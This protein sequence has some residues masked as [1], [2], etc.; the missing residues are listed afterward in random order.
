MS[1]EL[2]NS[3]WFAYRGS[4]DSGS[5]FQAAVDAILCSFPG[6]DAPSACKE[7]ARMV[8]MPPPGIGARRR[9]RPPIVSILPFSTLAAHTRRDAS[10][11]RRR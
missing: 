5:R 7:A 11:E 10:A 9:S 2:H 3:V 8:M 1:S 4:V 6:V